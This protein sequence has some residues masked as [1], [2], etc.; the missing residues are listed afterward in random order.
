M[1]IPGLPAGISKLK[2]AD[3]VIDITKSSKIADNVLDAENKTKK[4]EKISDISK[5][6]SKSKSINQLQKE[7][8]K[9]KAPKGI[10][11][12]D[13]T[14]DPKTGQPHVHFKDTKGSALNK[15][16]SWKEGYYDLSKKEIEYLRKNG[17]NINE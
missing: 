7:V 2:Y 5:S 13:K 10:E 4:S 3:D 12:F 17:W 1:A 11:R 15:D 6:E 9:G 14:H 16:G 8:E